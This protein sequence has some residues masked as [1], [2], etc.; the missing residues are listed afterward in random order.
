MKKC[1]IIPLNSAEKRVSCSFE[2]YKFRQ[3]G[4][5]EGTNYNTS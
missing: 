4:K 2:K 5:L 1:L 3:P